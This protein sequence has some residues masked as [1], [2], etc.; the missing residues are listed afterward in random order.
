MPVSLQGSSASPSVLEADRQR[1]RSAVAGVLAKSTRRD[2]ADLP[3]EP[4][5]LLDSPTYEGFAIRPLYTRLD[6]GSEPSLPGRWPFVRGGDARRDI[7]SGWKVAEVFPADGST[8]E[9]ANGALLVALTEG[10]SALMLRVGGAA[11]V[12]PAC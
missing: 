4:D 8:V 5:R 7:K 3:A 1:W 2:P 6:E 11:G 12:A 10:A 9:D